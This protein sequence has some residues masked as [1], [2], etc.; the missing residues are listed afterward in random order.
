LIRQ[1]PLTLGGD[2][3]TILLKLDLPA[4]RVIELVLDDRVLNV[5]GLG[6]ILLGC[7]DL[8]KQRTTHGLEELSPTRTRSPTT[9]M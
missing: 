9:S 3:E 1:R 4:H 5:I 6:L 7:D 8:R 2:D